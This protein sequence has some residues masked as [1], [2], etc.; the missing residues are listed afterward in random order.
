MKTQLSFILLMLLTSLL[1][2]CGKPTEE[3]QKE[4]SKE[5]PAIDIPE[6][7]IKSLFE[8]EEG[9]TLLHLKDFEEFSGKS[10]EPVS[11][12]NWT[13]KEGIISCQGQPQGYIYTRVA[14]GNCTVRLEYRFPEPAEKNEDPNTGLLFFITGENRIWPKCLEVQGKYSE[15]A[16]IKSNSKDITLEVTDDPQARDKARRPIGEW[17]AI[18][19]ICKDGALTSILNG[20][21]I[22]SS[23]P[24]ELKEGFF[25]L[26]S[27][28]NPVEFRNIRV[29]QLTD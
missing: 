6:K 18:E 20:D 15:M 4:A 23:K 14:M 22:A 28:G 8:V 11:G 17:N 19:V 3:Q 29:Q 2:A 9:F 10:K 25:G 16:H 21:R 12:K 7:T 26:Q 27:E 1:A 24:S 13:E 5:V